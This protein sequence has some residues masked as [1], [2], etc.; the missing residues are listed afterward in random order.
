[1][2]VYRFA[3]IALA[4]VVFSAFTA[5]SANAAT[6]QLCLHLNGAA[7]SDTFYL[8]FNVQGSAIMV[9]GRRGVFSDDGGPVFGT[10]TQIPLRPGSFEMG[11]TTTISNSGDYMGPNT[12]NVVIFFAPGGVMTYNRWLNSNQAFTVGTV[13][14][15]TCVA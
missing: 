14:L 13:S 1:M 10:L 3:L 11:L 8:N 7:G 9:G 5:R 4:T 6:W 12:E 2:R 15:A